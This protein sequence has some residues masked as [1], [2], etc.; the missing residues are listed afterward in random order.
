MRNGMVWYGMQWD[1]FDDV[2]FCLVLRWPSFF[3]S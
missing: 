3:L 1:D 2:S